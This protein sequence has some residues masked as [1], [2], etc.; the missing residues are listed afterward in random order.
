MY[1]YVQIEKVC[2]KNCWKIKFIRQ[3]LLKNQKIENINFDGNIGKNSEI[4]FRNKFLEITHF[5]NIRAE[6]K[7]SKIKFGPMCK[8]HISRNT[9]VL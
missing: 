3:N 8:L 4:K 9:S 6:H 1:K 7:N 5:E 2:I